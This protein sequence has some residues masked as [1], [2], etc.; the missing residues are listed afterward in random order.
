MARDE[1]LLEYKAGEEAAIISAIPS[2]R[3]DAMDV[4][5]SINQAPGSHPIATGLPGLTDLPEMQ[6]IG[7]IFDEMPHQSRWG[8][9]EM[10]N[11]N[12][13]LPLDWVWLLGGESVYQTY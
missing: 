4:S 11:S 7:E 2:P 6:P 10:D 1:A 13:G 12:Q 3:L 5:H 9:P 8:L